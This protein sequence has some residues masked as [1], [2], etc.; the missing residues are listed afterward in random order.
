MR[1]HLENQ[2]DTVAFGTEN[3]QMKLTSRWALEV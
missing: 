2:I 3:L 1:L